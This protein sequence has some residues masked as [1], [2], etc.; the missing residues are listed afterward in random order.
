[1]RR[2]TRVDNRVKTV[3]ELQRKFRIPERE[4]A[5][6]QHRTLKKKRV[7]IKECIELL[8]RYVPEAWVSI[9]G[10]KTLKAAAKKYQ[11]LI[12]ARDNHTRL[13]CSYWVDHGFRPVATQVPCGIVGLCYTR[14]D[15]IL[16]DPED[17]IVV[18]EIKTGGAGYY[19]NSTIYP[20]SHPFSDHNDCVLHQWMLQLGFTT[21]MYCRTYG[22]ME[23]RMGTPRLF[24]ITPTTIE[25]HALPSWIGGRMDEALAV[26]SKPS[27]L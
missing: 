25:S 27:K 22:S 11:G 12:N 17:R 18:G 15:V 2:G 19:M 10:E 23:K 5:E 14:V 13:L 4:C 20:L 9:Y 7:T 6:P 8:M 21:E 3:I 24:R 16:L 1:M 26:L